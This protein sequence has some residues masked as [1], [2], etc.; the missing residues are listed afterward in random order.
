MINGEFAFKRA[1]VYLLISA[2]EKRFM[3][4]S[5]CIVN[6]R[7]IIDIINIIIVIIIYV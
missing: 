1:E 2:F 6:I 7:I 5:V 4:S 3:C